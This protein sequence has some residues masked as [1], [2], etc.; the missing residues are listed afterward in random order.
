M[1][2]LKVLV[3]TI[4]FFNLFLV[5]TVLGYTQEAYPTKPIISVIPYPAGGATD[6][7]CRALGM[8]APKYFGQ[9]L[10][11]TNKVGLFHTRS[12]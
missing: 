9:P 6:L 5:F 10:V 3:G 11:P 2:T 8:F 7:A 1:K 12:L 4:L